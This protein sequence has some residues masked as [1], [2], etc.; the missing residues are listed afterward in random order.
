MISPL[1]LYK[2]KKSPAVLAAGLFFMLLLT[3]SGCS[4]R[5]GTGDFPAGS[6]DQHVQIPLYEIYPQEEIFAEEYTAEEDAEPRFLMPS[7][8]IIIDDIGYDPAMADRFLDLGGVLTFSLFPH[9][10]YRETIIQKIQAKGMEIMLHLPMEPA[11]Y[12]AV[13]PGPGAL[14]ISMSPLQFTAQLEKN[15]DSIKGI[16][17][18]NNHMGSRLTTVPSLM[19]RIFSELKKRDL[20]FIDS[21]TSQ[22]TVCPSTARMLQIPFAQR[23]VFLDHVQEAE[24]IRGQIRLL[25]RIAETC[26]EAV[27]IGHPHKVTWEVLAEEMPE[28]QKKVQLV[29][30]SRI[31]HTVG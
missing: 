6:P 31:V 19:Y 14:L 21:F 3:V 29:P 10:P 12:P 15:L 2:A 5:D 23:D 17:G 28:L 4:K 24:V 30:A 13:L 11:E 25:I 16:K 26:G 7:V 22:H 18:V 1:F 27:G 20:F 9:S 8:A